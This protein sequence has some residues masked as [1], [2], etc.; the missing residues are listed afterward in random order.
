MKQAMTVA[1]LRQ[2]CLGMLLVALSLPLLI[3]LHRKIGVE[4]PE[5][6]GVALM[7]A[8]VV[9]A[10]AGGALIG[11]AVREFGRGNK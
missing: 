6:G 5:F 10:F 1:A 4:A 9:L 3:T 11:V 2:A 8:S 7:A